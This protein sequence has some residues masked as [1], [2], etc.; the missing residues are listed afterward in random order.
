[1]ETCESSWVKIKGRDDCVRRKGG[2]EF[3]LLSDE[4]KDWS[5]MSVDGFGDAELLRI[6][7]E[8]G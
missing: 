6:K 3:G 8:R 2:R 1:M 7:G 4:L 5:K